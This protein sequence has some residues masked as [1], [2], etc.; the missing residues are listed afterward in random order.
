MQFL[1]GTS[2]EFKADKLKEICYFGQQSWVQ[3]VCTNTK[4]KFD[5][6]SFIENAKY[7][8][9]IEKLN[10]I[11]RAFKAMGKTTNC[12]SNHEKF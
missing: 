1:V 11:I 7:Y 2:A 12:G 4:Y 8:Y 5:N 3:M 10:K 6:Y 9:T